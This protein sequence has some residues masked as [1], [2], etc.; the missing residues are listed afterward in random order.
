MPC[1][2]CESLVHAPYPETG[3][4][5]N[6]EQ[7]GSGINLEIQNGYLVGFYYGYDAE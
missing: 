4:W 3:S 6:P 1:V 2:G 5:Y 7:S